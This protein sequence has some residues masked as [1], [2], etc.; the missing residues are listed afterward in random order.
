MDNRNN[1]PLGVGLTSVFTVLLVLTLS[2]FAV[3]T[4][5]TA[6]ADLALSQINAD[7]VSAYYA[8]DR[9]A[10]E[11]YNTFAAGTAAEFETSIPIR[12]GQSLHIRLG[13]D[14]E[15]LPLILAWETVPL[16]PE[17]EI[18]SDWNLWDGEPLS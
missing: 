2:I 7:T 13:R 1:L 4:L 18:S 16:E 14:T 15:G 11:H 5:S 17:G 10:A 12:A 9:L 3:L 6:R 8:A